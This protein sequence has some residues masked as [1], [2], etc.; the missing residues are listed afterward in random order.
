MKTY[1]KQDIEKT[2]KKLQVGKTGSRKEEIIE[3]LSSLNQKN[4][5]EDMALYLQTWIF[6]KLCKLIPELKK[7]EK[8]EGI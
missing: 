2:I 5:D 3:L 8:K 7:Q 6:P 4:T 1:T